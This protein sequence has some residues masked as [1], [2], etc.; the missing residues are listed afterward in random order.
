MPV[1]TFVCISLK[2]NILCNRNKT[3][4]IR[5]LSIGILSKNHHIPLQFH[6]LYQYCLCY[7]HDP[8]QNYVFDAVFILLF[9]NLSSLPVTL[10]SLIILTIIGHSFCSTFINLG[11]SFPH[12]QIQVICLLQAGRNMR[13]VM[14]SDSY[15]VAHNFD[16]YHY[17]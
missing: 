14:L 1:I 17:C 4:K 15:Q 11:S 2:N 3:I 6:K 9:F 8:A 16:L 7:Q 12:N 10:R 5:I 13:A